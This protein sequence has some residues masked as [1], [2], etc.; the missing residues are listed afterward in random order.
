MRPGLVE[1]R[2]YEYIR[3]GTAW[4]PKPATLD[5]DLGRG[6]VAADPGALASTSP[7]AMLRQNV[8][9][10]TRTMAR[11]S[12]LR[13]IPA[14]NAGSWLGCGRWNGARWQSADSVIPGV[15]TDFMAVREVS[16]QAGRD[17]RTRQLAADCDLDLAWFVHRSFKKIT[18]F[19]THL[20]HTLAKPFRWTYQGKPLTA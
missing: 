4:S 1:Q 20:N 17:A 7:A 15:P 18:A 5:I 14:C 16:A 13:S 12:P 11:L 19:M 3:H 10:A 6:A 9:S 8:S 2:E